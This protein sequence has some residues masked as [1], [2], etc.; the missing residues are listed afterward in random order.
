MFELDRSDESA[1][2]TELARS[3]A[4]SLLSPAARDAD[5]NRSTPSDV[6]RTLFDTG[7]TVPVAEQFRGGGIPSVTTHLAAVEALAYGDAGLTMAAMWNGGAALIIGRCGS[8]AQQAAWLPGLGG[9][10]NRRSSVALYEG[11][12]RAPS[13]SKTTITKAA[14]DVRVQGRKLSVPFANVADP[15]VVVGV[16]ASG[17][18]AA[19]ILAPSEATITPDDTKIALGAVPTFTVDFD[20]T[21]PADRLIANVAE[22]ELAVGWIRLMVAAAQCGTAQRATDYASKYATERIAFGKPIATFQGVSFML[23]D[24]ALR[25]GAARLEMFDAAA[26]IDAEHATSTEAMPLPAPSTTPAPSPRHAT[27]DALQVLGGHGFITD[28]PVEL[29]YRSAA[30]LSVLDFDPLL[31]QLRTV[32]SDKHRRTDAMTMIDEPRHRLHTLFDLSPELQAYGQ[33]LRDWSV[34]YFRPYARIADETHN[35]PENWREF[36][37]KCPVPIGRRDKRTSEPMPD[38]HRRQVGPRPGDHRGPQLRRHLGQ[39]RQG[40]ASGISP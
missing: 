37:D 38:I 35:A 8:P 18:L 30:A 28:H 4:D 25:I 32:R 21:V 33:A 9:D 22:L 31:S 14:N 7:L 10:S 15:I 20:T 39:R 6:A 27:R 16:D 11:F 5:R 2:V 34:Q 12:G 40:Q 13:E 3:L 36:L 26:H 19:A 23:A 1:A 24:C 17:K 29:W